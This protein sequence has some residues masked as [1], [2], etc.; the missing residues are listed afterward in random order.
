[1]WQVLNGTSATTKNELPYA[2]YIISLDASY[3]KS[4]F[5]LVGENL[6]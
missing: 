1:M 5:T 6:I 2:Q 4:I 3:K